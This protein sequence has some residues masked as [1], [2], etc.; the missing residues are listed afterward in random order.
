MSATEAINRYERQERIGGWD[1]SKLKNAKIAIVGAEHIG[2]FLASDFAALGVGDIRVYDNS[3]I[4]YRIRDIPYNQREFLMTRAKE[5]A[6]KAETLEK[7]IV[8]VNPLVNFIG[9]HISL[10]SVTECLVEMPDM[11]I[12]ATNDQKMAKCWGDFFTGKNVETYTAA[13]DVNGAFFQAYKSSFTSDI[14]GEQ[15]GITSEVISGHL[16]GEIMQRIMYGKKIEA[17]RYSPFGERFLL[18]GNKIN[19]APLDKKKALV[20]GAGALG[21]FLGIGLVHAGVGEIYF[22]DDDI[23]EQTNLN[24]QILFY[25]AVGEYKADVLARRLSTINPSIKIE[26]IKKRV[27]EDFEPDIKKISPDVLIDGVD[28]LPT[29]AILNHFALEYRIPLISGGTDHEKGQVVVYV[30]EKSSCLNCKMGVD[31]ALVEARQSR[32]CINAPTSSVVVVNHTIGG[33]MAAEARCTLDSENYGEPV[34]KTIKYDMTKPVRAGLISTDKPCTCR[35]GV[36]A[37]TWIGKIMKKAASP[38]QNQ[39]LNEEGKNK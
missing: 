9:M 38:N 39:K 6:S 23:V 15:D 7:R 26:P 18:N 2:T 24:R 3:R 1:Q 22:V 33:H 31:K 14:E 8:M 36:S 5:N 35:R 20:V 11:A 29:R 25:D 16:A 34:R 21:N 13:G 10:D 30:P 28:N 37:K 17:L 32:S 12:I 19:P 4:D 27:T